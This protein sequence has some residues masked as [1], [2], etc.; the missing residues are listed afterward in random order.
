MRK[1]SNQA[2]A[3]KRVIIGWVDA[4]VDCASTIIILLGYCGKMKNTES[5]HG[6]MHEQYDPWDLRQSHFMHFVGCGLRRNH[7]VQGTTCRYD[8]L[9]A[10]ILL[11]KI[12]ANQLKNKKFLFNKKQK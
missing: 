4:M 6:S 2:K 1:T 5:M 7:D 12:L 8:V 10:H 9:Y 11:Q 3:L